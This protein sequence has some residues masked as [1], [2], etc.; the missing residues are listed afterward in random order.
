MDR[1]PEL[2]NEGISMEIALADLENY[3]SP[4][5]FAFRLRSEFN[6]AERSKASMNMQ[7]TIVDV[8]TGDIV[9]QKSLTDQA[10]KSI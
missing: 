3:N 10:S 2:Q 8:Q 7:V 9:A 5:G 6:A 4:D 1:N